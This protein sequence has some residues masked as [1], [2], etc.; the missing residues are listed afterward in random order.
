MNKIDRAT[1]EAILGKSLEKLCIK[2][3][4]GQ[5]NGMLVDI[6][7]TN[8]II[9]QKKTTVIPFNTILNIT[10]GINKNIS[11]LYQN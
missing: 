4:K 10:S 1:I 9:S 3:T 5:K 8:I 2:T 7:E 11:V 6:S